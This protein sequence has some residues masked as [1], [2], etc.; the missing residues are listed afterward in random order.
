MF[1]YYKYIAYICKVKS[2][3]AY[4]KYSKQPNGIKQQMKYQNYSKWKKN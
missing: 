4:K 3:Q 2:K 1:W